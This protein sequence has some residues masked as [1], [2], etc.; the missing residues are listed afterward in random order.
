VK[1]LDLRGAAN[2]RFAHVPKGS[3]ASLAAQAACTDRALEEVAQLRTVC[4]GRGGQARAARR[5]Q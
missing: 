4:V 3:T 2:D 5:V 1:A